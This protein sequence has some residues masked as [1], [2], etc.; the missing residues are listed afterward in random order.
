MKYRV[1]TRDCPIGLEMVLSV[2]VNLSVVIKVDYKFF[3]YWLT[4]LLKICK[5]IVPSAKSF[6][7]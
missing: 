3:W 6:I 1:L 7:D 4:K 5:K 2:M